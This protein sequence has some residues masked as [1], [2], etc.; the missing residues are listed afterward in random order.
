MYLVVAS[1]KKAIIFV[2]DAM[3][4]RPFQPTDVPQIAQLFHDTIRTVNL[5][6]YSL[7]QVRAWAPDDLYFRDWDKMCGDRHTFVA[8]E[9]NI[10]LGF[11]ELEKSGRIDCFYCHKDYQGHGVG[12]R[13]YQAIETKA[14][15][16]LLPRLTVDASI[17]A[18]IFFQ[19][20]G[21]SVV[22]EQQVSTRG[23][24]FTNYLLEKTLNSDQII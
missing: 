9:N 18:K 5:S 23:Q 10:I 4:I 13:I 17:T 24:V 12:S 6:D 11:G 19:K 20:M 16:L 7:D 2:L 21:F 3:L 1:F 8:A 14:D 22:R 15:S